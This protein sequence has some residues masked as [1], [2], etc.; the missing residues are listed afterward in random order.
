MKRIGLIILVLLAIL[1][2][3]FL[4]L[5]HSPPAPPA[6]TLLPESTLAFLHLPDMAR[7]RAA[8]TNTAAFALWQEPEIQ[9]LLDQPRRAFYEATGMPTNSTRQHPALTLLEGVEGEL[10]LA[11]VRFSALPSPQ[12]AIVFGGD[13]KSNLLRTRTAL[14]YHEHWLRTHNPDRQFVTKKHLGIKYSVWQF[15][16]NQ[17][18]CH[19]F[20]NSL[21]VFT[22]DETTLQEVIA[23]FAG[24]APAD[25]PSLAT[26]AKYQ[27]AILQLPASPTLTAYFNIEQAT[28]L[29]SPLLALASQGA[30]T[31]QQLTRIRSMAIGTTFVDGQF[32][33]TGITIYSRDNDKLPPPIARRTLALTTPQ[34]TLYSVQPVDWSTGYKELLDTL[35]LSGQPALLASATQFE[36]TLRR[37][38]IRPQQDF[39]AQLGPETAVIATWRE[40]ARLPA[41]AIVAEI[42]NATAFRPR[43]LPVMNALKDALAGT[44]NDVPW[45]T[46]TVQGETL[47][48]VRL[49]A[50]LVAPTYCATDQFFLFALTPDFA[51]DLLRQLQTPQPTL[52]ANTQYQRMMSRLPTNGSAY[53]YCD[54]PAMIRP[55]YALVPHTTG[56]HPETIARHLTPYASATVTEAKSET[57]T[58]LSPLGKPVT[59]LATLAGIIAAIQPNLSAGFNPAAPTTSSNKLVPPPPAGNQ[60]APSQTPLRP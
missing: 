25:S 60:T 6:A 22:L 1:T 39:F 46:T 56:P 34:T 47:H 48:T 42:Q 15:Q 58:T 27:D 40:G 16:P 3:L 23:R 11:V 53:V 17:Q 13:L 54:L 30:S 19:A 38:G 55:L 14:A 41:A 8:F 57:T 35:A 44:S 24:Q 12:A 50:G 43:L 52:E 20:L 37:Q 26:S 7:A 29:I 2:G 31:L 59:V 28:R 51:R 9:A 4:W 21:V 33:D 49:G 45:E 5:R 10:F 18:L 36:R 32:Q